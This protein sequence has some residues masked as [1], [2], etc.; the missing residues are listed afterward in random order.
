M[1]HATS[2]ETLARSLKALD[3]MVGLEPVKRQV[4]DLTDFL[5]ITALR[6]DQGLKTPELS[7]HLVFVGN[8]G[9]GKTTVARRIAEIYAALGI[10][11]R[12]LVVECARADLV[13]GYIGQTAIK[14][15]AKFEEARGG[16]LFIDEAYSLDVGEDAGWDFG[17]EAIDTLLKLMEDNRLAVRV[18]VAGYP[19]LMRGFLEMNPGLDSRFDR[20]IAFPDYTPDELVRIFE[21]LCGESDYEPLADAVDAVRAFISEQRRD[22]SFGNARMIRKLFESSIGAQASRLSATGA[23]PA[24]EALPILTGADIE[25][26]SRALAD[27]DDEDKGPEAS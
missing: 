23:P 9:T 19:K 14:T 17:R 4:R 21:G 26:A 13:G 24:M 8:P 11:D 22:E 27:P 3:D 18:I 12:P 1:G 25:A 20:T 5:K 6:H 10:S 16:V 7:H 2:E 15:A